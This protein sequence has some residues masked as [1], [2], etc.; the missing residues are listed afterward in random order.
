[1]TSTITRREWGTLPDGRT[2]HLYTIT[3]T[4]GRCVSIS[5]YGGIITG[6][7]GPDRD[8]RMGDIVLGY[9]TLDEYFE[10]NAYLGAMIGRFSNRIAGAA[11]TLNGQQ[12]RLTA[13]EGRNI[14]HGG[15]GF[16]TRL[17][18]AEIIENGVRLHYLSPNGEDGFPGNLEVT[19]VVTFA[20]VLNIE[21]TAVP[22]QDTVI[23]LTNHSFFNLRG[24][25]NV[26]SHRLSINADEY[27]TVDKELIPVA[28][29][30]VAN[31][32]FDFRA[33]REIRDGSYDH[34]FVLDGA[35]PAAS[36]YDP[37]SG[38][39]LELRTNMPCLQFYAAGCLGKRRGKGGAGYDNHSGLALEPQHFPDSPNRPD[40]P[41]P[42]V[43]AGETY[44]HLISYRFGVRKP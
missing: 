17:W 27:L 24:G 3:D 5:N 8:G 2:V 23:S 11:F 26:L 15:R 22:D 18:D 41:S 35:D 33:P 4:D 12:Y 19:A 28:R 43:R 39:T 7:I 13:N 34:A 42:V 29:A 40:F 9:D 44:R 20:D 38:R 32:P 1:M 25:G 31:T 14:L 36:L 16:N 10:D 37:E 6:I 30:P 21:F